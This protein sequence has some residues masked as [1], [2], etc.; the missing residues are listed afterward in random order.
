MRAASRPRQARSP[1]S[2]RGACAR[3]G[4]GEAADARPTLERAR[5]ELREARKAADTLRLREAA[6]KAYLAATQAAD[7]VAVAQGHLPPEGTGGRLQALARLDRATRT[8][9]TVAAFGQVHLALH[10]ECFHEGRCDP[11]RVREGFRAA[12][13]LFA[14]VS[15]H[16]SCPPRRRDS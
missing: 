14:Q 5:A 10:G 7:C 4:P 15:K 13:A 2:Q 6:E 11:A 9:R 1:A 16:F 12:A 8:T 3:A